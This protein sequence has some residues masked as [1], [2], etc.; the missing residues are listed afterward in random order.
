MRESRRALDALTVAVVQLDLVS[1]R[2]RLRGLDGVDAARDAA[3]AREI[4]A[5]CRRVLAMEADLA[6]P[7]PTGRP[8]CLGCIRAACAGRPWGC[9]CEWDRVLP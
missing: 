4:D 5:M 2:R 7:A 1:K 8:L 3:I 6:T 9:G